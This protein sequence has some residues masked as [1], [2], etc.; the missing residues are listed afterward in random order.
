MPLLTNCSLQLTLSRSKVVMI[1]PK[2]SLKT[3]KCMKA[4]LNCVASSVSS[5]GRTHQSVQMQIP[6]W[7]TL[8]FRSIKTWRHLRNSV[9]YHSNADTNNSPLTPHIFISS[10]IFAHASLQN[11]PQMFVSCYLYASNGMKGMHWISTFVCWIFAKTAF[12]CF[13]AKTNEFLYSSM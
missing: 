3:F 12:L 9:D 6:Y 5:S 8:S 11:D 4:L 10:F 1:F 2:S 7:C 13:E